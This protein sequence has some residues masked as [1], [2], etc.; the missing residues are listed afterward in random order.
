MPKH[1]TRKWKS[2][3][4]SLR[5]N[6]QCRVI[7][8]FAKKIGPIHEKSLANAKLEPRSISRLSSV[9]FIL[10]LCYLGD[11]NLRASTC[12]AKNASVEI[13]LRTS[14]VEQVMRS[15]GYTSRYIKVRDR[16]L[17]LVTTFSPPPHP[18]P[19][20]RPIHP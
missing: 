19:S 9:L 5:L 18:P 14:K 2:T 17:P 12:L 13:K 11:L 20:C 8:T 7:F 10:P 15:T 4:R 6:F 16:N 1:E 3:L